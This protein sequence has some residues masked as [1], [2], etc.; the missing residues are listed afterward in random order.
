MLISADVVWSPLRRSFSPPPRGGVAARPSKSRGASLARADGVVSR[1]N[2][3]LWNLI[4]TP[5]A[6]TE[7]A[8]RHFIDVAATPPRRGGEKP[9]P[10]RTPKP[11]PNIDIVPNAHGTGFPLPVRVNL[12]SC[13]FRRGVLTWPPI[14]PKTY[15]N[16]LPTQLRQFCLFKEGNVA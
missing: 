12:D 8:P 6:P 11:Q 16:L 2:K 7:V 10:Q 4:T 1:L 5:S 9:G 13:A 15:T 3:I 14:P